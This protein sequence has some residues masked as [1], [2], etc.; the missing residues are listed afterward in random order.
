MNV[1]EFHTGGR[2]AHK[3][4][5]DSFDRSI[6]ASAWYDKDGKL[7]DAEIVYPHGLTRA[8]CVGGPIWKLLQ[9]KA[10]AVFRAAPAGREKRV[11]HSG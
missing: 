6:V 9:A 8:V 3:V 5:V 10:S 2:A 11:V 4:R 7:L 1:I